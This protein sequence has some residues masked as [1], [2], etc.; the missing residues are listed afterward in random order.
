MKNFSFILLFFLS[1]QTTITSQTT[2]SQQ[3][4][5][6]SLIY[7]TTNEFRKF[8]IYLP[9]NY[10]NSGKTYKTLYMHDGQN[11][12]NKSTSYSGEWQVDEYLDKIENDDC[13]LIAIA[14]GEAHRI[15]ELTPFPNSKY[16]GGHADEYLLFLT[17]KVIP[18]INKTYRTKTETENTL[19]MGSSLGGL[20]SL[21]AGIKHQDI[22]GGIASFSPS[23]WF[24]SDIFE[25]VKQQDINKKL[26]FYFM[27]G[28]NEEAS[29]KAN[30]NK[31][32]NLLLD[33]GL[34]APQII[35]KIAPMGEHN[36]AL[37]AQEFPEA[38]NF[39]IQN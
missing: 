10:Q 21:Y 20:V 18:Y 36:E 3:V 11:I 1:F 24:S 9:K 34:P 29:T 32:V 12:F 27:S 16:G 28:G 35:N 25:F 13:I 15:D 38:Y 31:M 30:Q 4:T 6:D 23:L 14:H 8:W 37:W 17:Q 39:L 7:N 5:I 19:I 2:A 22:F 26:K 33:K